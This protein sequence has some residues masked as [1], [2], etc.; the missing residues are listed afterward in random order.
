MCVHLGI[1]IAQLRRVRM[2]TASA[3][4]TARRK[5]AKRRKCAAR[6]RCMASSLEG[7]NGGA[8]NVELSTFTPFGE[9]LDNILQKL[10][11]DNIL[12]VGRKQF[13]PLF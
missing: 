2:R 10:R 5:R 13:L 3:A 1:T 12:N 11:R 8:K 7:Q 6:Y 4:R 9:S